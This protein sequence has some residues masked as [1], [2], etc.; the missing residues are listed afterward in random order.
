MAERWIKHWMVPRSSGEGDWTVAI[1]KNGVYGCS[2]P[3]W[4]FRRLECHH[5]K[6]V[7]MGCYPEAEQKPRPIP[8]LAMVAKPI[9]NGKTNE[10][11][12]PLIKIPAAQLIKATIC[13]YLM[14]H[15]YSWT[16]VNEIRQHIPHSWTRSVMLAHVERYGEAK[17][18]E[19][20]CINLKEFIG[21][22]YIC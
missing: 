9:F 7:K 8:R 1:D 14:K 3:V 13:Y 2:C 20:K 4:K 22:I 16:E 11:L 21:H 12:I 17:Y 5:I 10:L 18:A 6:Q 19:S 15:G